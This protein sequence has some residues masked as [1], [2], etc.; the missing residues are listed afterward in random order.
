MVQMPG[1]VPVATMAVGKAG[2]RNAAIFATQILSLS[3]QEK[4]QRLLSFKEGL[5]RQVEE[6]GREMGRKACPDGQQTH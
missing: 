5:A 3:C 6:E 4:A 2:A 1:G